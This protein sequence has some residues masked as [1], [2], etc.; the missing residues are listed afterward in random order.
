MRSLIAEH[1]SASQEP[2]LH[3]SANVA[4]D[5]LTG[6]VDPPTP[7]LISSGHWN[8]NQTYEFYAMVDLHGDRLG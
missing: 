5:R 7:L 8:S 4:Y 1:G 6:F 3:D 2:K